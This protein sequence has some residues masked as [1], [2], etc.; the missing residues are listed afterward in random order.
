M[1]KSGLPGE[2]PTPSARPAAASPS[3]FRARA[4]TLALVAALSFALGVG[5]ALAF[6]SRSPAGD[7]GAPGSAAPAAAAPGDHATMPGMDHGAMPGRESG[8]GGEHPAQAKGGTVYVS[9][10]RQQ[11]VGVRTATIERQPLSAMLRTVGTLA[12]DETR[13]AQ[14]HTKVSGWV[15]RVFVDYVGKEVAKGA[16]LFTVYSPELVS[17]QREYLLA[18][19]AKEALGPRA[20]MLGLAD[21]DTLAA[22]ARDRLRLWDVSEQQI[23]ALQKSG[24]IRKTLTLNSPFEGIVL[25]RNAFPGQYV[26]PENEIFKIA[27][28]STIWVLGEVFEYELPAVRTGQ[29]V[30]IDFPYGQWKGTL[31]GKITYVYPS[32]DPQTRRVR[33]R[34]EFDNPGLEFKPGSYVT[35]TLRTKL[36][37]T[38]AIAKE[39]VIDTGVKRIAILAHPNGY[40][41]PREISVGDPVGDLYPLLGGL[42]EGDRVVVSA[43]FLIDSETNLAAAL[44]AMSMSMPGMDMGGE[45]REDGEQGSPSTAPGGHGTHAP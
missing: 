4:G 20:S 13:V 28:L 31:V 45:K 44:Q 18:L 15:E 38:L 17:T 11:M 33:V 12:Y 14:V 3:G 10:A 40:F 23:D 36:P 25:E 34:V 39:A 6:F 16:P 29:E 19:R 35:V 42:S 1:A 7:A 41:E 9:P 2:D 21:G 32:I 24:E 8:P 30:E 22:I 26:S 37:P 27:D 5:A 43:Q